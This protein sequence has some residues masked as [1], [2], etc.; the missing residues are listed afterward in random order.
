MNQRI[1]QSNLFGLMLHFNYNF[2]YQKL[3]LLLR[4]LF[5]IVHA[6][7]DEQHAFQNQIVNR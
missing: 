3:F 5:L 4:Q 2:L 1:Y 7:E 6:L